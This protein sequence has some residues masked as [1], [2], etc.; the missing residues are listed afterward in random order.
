MKFMDVGITILRI[1]TGL[2]FLAHGL[3][4]LQG[5]IDNT[6]QYFESLGIPGILAVVVTGA[7][8]FGGLSLILG[9]GTRIA[10][11]LLIPVM[12]GAIYFVHFPQ[13]FIRNEAGPGYELNLILMASCIQLCLT[14]NHFFALDRLFV[15]E[16]KIPTKLSKWYL[17]KR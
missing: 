13:G 1:V 4:K 3:A 9:I 6:G 10:A 15:K 11:I 2:I 12:L 5:G 14:T 17:E 8:L 7:E 16:K